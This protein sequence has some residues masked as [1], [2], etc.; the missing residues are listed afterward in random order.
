[1]DDSDQELIKILIKR[2]DLKEIVENFSNQN[3]T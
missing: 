2:I 3:Y 1:M